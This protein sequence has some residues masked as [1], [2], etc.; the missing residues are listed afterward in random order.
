MGNRLTIQKIK[1]RCQ[2]W[3]R[4][5][6]AS[7]IDQGKKMKKNHRILIWMKQMDI[8]IETANIKRLIKEYFGQL[9]TIWQLGKK[10][11]SYKT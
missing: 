10:K 8:T 2:F 5:M 1:A 4:L 7:K 9:Y 6:Q 3:K 11:D